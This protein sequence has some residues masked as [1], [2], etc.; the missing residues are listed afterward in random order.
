[1]RDGDGAVATFGQ[2]QGGGGL[3]DD[4]RAADDDGVLAGGLDA[5]AAEEFD[6]LDRRNDESFLYGLLSSAMIIS[7]Y[8]DASSGLFNLSSTRD[9]FRRT[10]RRR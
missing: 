7:R 3:A 10:T 1:M 4:E 2:E 8:F 6:D 5:G 9:K